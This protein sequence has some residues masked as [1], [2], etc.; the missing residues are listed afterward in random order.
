[1]NYDAVPTALKDR[2]QWVTWRYEKEGKPVSKDTEGATKIPYNPRTGHRAS[3][4]NPNTWTSY[5]TATQA[6]AA[7]KHNGIGFV[8]SEDD[9]FTGIDLD[10]CIDPDGSLQSWAESIVATM[11]S[12]TEISPSGSG[13]KIWVEGDIPS[14]IK[15]PQI[16]MYCKGRYFT[17]TGQRFDSAPTTIRNVNGALSDL[18]DSVKK[19]T[20]TP[21]PVPLPRATIGDEHAVAWARRKLADAIRMVTLAPDGVKHDT[22]IDAG[23]LAGGVVPLVSES[24][25]ETALYAAIEGRAADK[26]AALRTIRDGIRMGMQSPLPVP[27]PP[28]QPVFDAAGFACCPVHHTQLDPAKNGNGYKCRQRDAT[29]ASGWCDFWWSGAGYIA[30]REATAEPVIV[31]GELITQSSIA[32][33]QGAPRYVLYKLSGLRALPPA[34]WLINGEIPAG[35]T[36]IICGP[37]GA[38]KSFLMIDYVMRVARANPDRIVVYIAPEGGTGYHLRTQAWLN[39]FGGEEPENVLFILQAV[40]LLDPKAV[41]DLITI[42]RPFSPVMLVIDTLARCLVGGD[43]NSAKD[44]GMFFYH[45][46]LIRMETDAAIAVVHHT[47]KSGAF[48][49]SSALYGSVESW[50]DVTN[51]DGLITVSCGKSKDSEPFP[52]RYLRMVPSANSVVL[53][54]SDQVDS[55]NAPLSEGQRTILETL[56]LGI[57]REAGAKRSEIVSASG[58]NDRT[59]FRILSRMKQDRLIN[60]SKKGDPYFISDEGMEAIRLYHRTLRQKRNAEQLANSESVPSAE[61]AISQT[62]SNQ[63]SASAPDQ[64][65]SSTNSH[66]YKGGASSLRDQDARSESPQLGTGWRDV[67]LFPKDA[68][69]TESLPVITPP[70]ARALGAAALDWSFLRKAFAAGDYAAISTHCSIYRGD[71]ESVLGQLEAEQGIQISDEET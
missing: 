57:F 45:T 29:T 38:G 48:R 18:Y 26:H 66:P 32:T 51:D 21:S 49:G 9:P 31:A 28:P 5:A 27:P 70:A 47:G 63:I 34:T 55:R 11:D 3:S 24:E 17:V 46:D 60:Q 69:H 30:P 4:T 2:A 6:A 15:T 54:P 40:P 14:S 19:E 1:M 56:S 36:T 35:L 8:F 58:I 42:I 59:I 37:S 10:D 23:R 44:I 33:A 41:H 50:I 20:P 43:E 52:P 64:L 68:H 71:A 13:V 61:V 53:L 16:E 7:R 62:S 39:H 25:I 22:L 67:D 65:A 12:Y